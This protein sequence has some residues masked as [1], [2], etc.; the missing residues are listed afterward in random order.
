MA[1]PE[2]NRLGRRAR[3]LQGISSGYETGAAKPIDRGKGKVSR[4]VLRRGTS[5]RAA[6]HE[7]V[8]W[9]MNSLSKRNGDEGA[10]GDF[11]RQRQNE[12][13]HTE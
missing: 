8:S 9:M 12:Y 13:G 5:D 3:K 6:I 10:S 1:A 4:E 2:L 11:G 7:D